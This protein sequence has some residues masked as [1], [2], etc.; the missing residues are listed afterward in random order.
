MKKETDTFEA[1]SGC[2][3][4]RRLR[5]FRNYISVKKKTKH[6]SPFKRRKFSELCLGNAGF[7]SEEAQR[8]FE[9]PQSPLRPCRLG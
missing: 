8:A 3:R 2:R 6:N 1:E 5:K 9:M 7:L 4:R